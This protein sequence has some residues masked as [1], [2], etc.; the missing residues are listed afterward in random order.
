MKLLYGFSL[1]IEFYELIIFTLLFHR[2]I[3]EDSNNKSEEFEKIYSKLKYMSDDSDF[4][5]NKN[6]TYIYNSQI[7][8]VLNIYYKKKK[9]KFI[10]F[11]LNSIYIL[12]NESYNEK[13]FD[14]IN[15]NKSTL[16]EE[17]NNKLFKLNEIIL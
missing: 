4:R 9:K 10:H 14:F 5:D 1:Y 17:L 13:W 2:K 16:N 3:C 11:D 8:K 7:S 15:P 6:H 12:I